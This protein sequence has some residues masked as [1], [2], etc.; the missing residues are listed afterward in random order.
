M[1]VEQA[2]AKYGK[3]I[4]GLWLDEAKWCK[5]IQ[6]PSVIGQHWIN[7]LSGKPV[8]RIYCN[9]DMATP[10]MDALNALL[11]KGILDELK[12]FD[13]C[14]K[15][16]MIRGSQT[17]MSAHSWAAAI[18]V[19]ASTNQLG[20]QPTLSKT[21]VESFTDAGFFWGGNFKRKDGMHF[22]LLGF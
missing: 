2:E 9:N 16:R 8:E 12:T 17:L 11:M 1:T 19:N 21:F 13:G 18:D 4:G 7:T 14:F 5:S 3:I 6:I 10:L 20:M 15:I 22:S